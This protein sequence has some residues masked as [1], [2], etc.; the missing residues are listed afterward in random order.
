M[1]VIIIHMLEGRAHWS[2]YLCIYSL[3]LPVGQIHS[4]TFSFG[5]ILCRRLFFYVRFLPLMYSKVINVL[6]SKVR[7]LFTNKLVSG[8][9][10]LI[11]SHLS[12]NFNHES[13]V[14]FLM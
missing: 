9:L 7:D 11:K 10:K 8:S 4:G 2:M 6:Y 1:C 12:N 14:I 3:Y 13:H 5:Y